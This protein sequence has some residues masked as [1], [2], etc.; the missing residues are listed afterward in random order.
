MSRL[1]SLSQ[2]LFSQNGFITIISKTSKVAT[3]KDILHKYVKGFILFIYLIICG[4]RH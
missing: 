3:K 4:L 1:D 2:T